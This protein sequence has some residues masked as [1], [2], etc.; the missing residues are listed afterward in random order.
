AGHTEAECGDAAARQT[1]SASDQPAAAAQT[2]E[3]AAT[4]PA[5]PESAVADVLTTT[6]AQAV[7]ESPAAAPVE[8]A[9]EAALGPAAPVSPRARRGRQLL[10]DAVLRRMG[11]LNALD[12]RMY[13]AIND[14]P[15]TGAPDSLAW[16]LARI[17]TGGWIWV[18]GTL[19]AYLV[20][21]PN[22]WLALKRLLPRLVLAT[23]LV[24]YPIKA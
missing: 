16:G 23:C 5:A 20:R 4:T 13:L 1:H 2:I 3:H 15:P 18:L 21:V 24:E 19:V 14:A 8:R 11:P 17:A 7:S 6:A 12:A 22:S 9:P 10:K